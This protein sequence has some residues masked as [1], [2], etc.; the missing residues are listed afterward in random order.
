MFS[1]RSWVRRL[2]QWVSL[3]ARRRARLTR[4]P[5]TIPP[6][7]EQLEMRTLLSTFT[8][9]T[10]A[11]AGAGSLRQAILDSNTASPGPNTIAFNIGG[12]GGHFI[13]PASPLPTITNPV[14][15]DGTTQPGFSIGTSLVVLEGGSTPNALDISAGNSTV[16][17]LGFE[18]FSQ[19]AITLES[20]GGNLVQN[21]QIEGNTVGIL[22]TSS[23][24]T[25]GGTTA[26]ARNI[27]SLNTDGIYVTGTANLIEGN[28]IGTDQIGTSAA[29][30][31]HDGVL[32]TG[33]SNQIG[34]SAVGASNVISS[35]TQ[36]GVSI[37]G[38]GATGNLVYNNYIGTGPGGGGSLPNG[39]GA[40]NIASGDSASVAG[41]FNGAVNDNGTLDLAGNAVS[42]LGALTSSGTVTNS[43]ASGTAALTVNGTGTF[44][45]VIQDG[46]T[47]TTAL[48]VAGGTV[49]LSGANTFTGNVTID[50]ST[51]D[52]ANDV[53]AFARTSS[54]LGNPAVAGRT[55][56]ISPQISAQV[57]DVPVTDNQ[58]VD[59]G[60][61][62][63]RL[64][65]SDSK[66]QADQAKAQVDAARANIANIEAQIRENEDIFGRGAA[67][68]QE[69]EP[70]EV[71]N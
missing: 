34:C 55:V 27:I 14:I 67:I 2:S 4:K 45:G 25:I 58:T 36:Y 64:D 50:S 49:T 12:G 6:G 24:N 69:T 41:T 21:N 30:N 65:D 1:F 60:T 70:I 62:L 28:Y 19:S 51:L 7:V 71:N 3:S 35:N 16:E 40:L 15:I 10:T 22:I 8:V 57:V 9:T 54:A 31:T 44:S 11:D 20:S 18:L 43:G 37:V 68:T 52:A 5:Q 59:A 32:V 23:M 42:V 26:S 13:T 63:V 29:G 56:T 17:G 38:S 39:V 46:A 53:N 66:A 33:S 47:A 48:T 61:V